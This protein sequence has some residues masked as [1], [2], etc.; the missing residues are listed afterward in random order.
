MSD[1]KYGQWQPIETAP[2]DGTWF[3]ACKPKLAAFVALI[4]DTDHP[5]CEYDGGVH[6]SW[7]H[8]YVDGVTHWMP[9]PVAPEDP[10]HA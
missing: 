9:L 5:D 3:L 4:L 1:S 8:K 7:D 2:T 6:C 10:G